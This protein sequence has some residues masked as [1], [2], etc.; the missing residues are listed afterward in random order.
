MYVQ[1]S[2]YG[3][4]HRVRDRGVM[5]TM[6]M[7]NTIQTLDAESC[8]P[9]T[10]LLKESS[11]SGNTW[12]PCHET[13]HITVK[14]CKSKS[15]ES[16]TDGHME[17]LPCKQTHAKQVLKRNRAEGEQCI[18]TND[19]LEDHTCLSLTSC[20][21]SVLNVQA[22][23]L[24]HL[25]R[26]LNHHQCIHQ[27]GAALG[28]REGTHLFLLTEGGLTADTDTAAASPL[29]VSCVS[30]WA[31]ARKSQSWQQPDHTP[32]HVS[33][34]GQSQQHFCIPWQ[35]WKVK[36]L[37]LVKHR[38]QQVQKWHKRVGNLIW[39]S[40]WNYFSLKCAHFNCVWFC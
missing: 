14:V 39:N 3:Q 37:N 31:N 19:P 30:S 23:R 15:L 32:E 4:S 8:K 11:K 24:G 12:L 29:C 16:C 22:K 1:N 27:P 35:G 18:K 40:L 13:R 17:R 20:T 9:W 7:S 5:S 28:G 33:L 34:Q 10:L 25:S 2:T 26:G 38:E 6:A 36:A 21:Q